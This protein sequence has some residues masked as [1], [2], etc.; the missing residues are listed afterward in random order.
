MKRRSL[1]R[2]RADVDV[3]VVQ[4][5]VKDAQGVFVS[6]TDMGSLADQAGLQHG[7]III[8]LNR[9]PIQSVEQYKDALGK[10]DLKRGALIFFNRQGT[11]SYALVK[12]A[13]ED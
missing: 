11:V 1:P 10:T 9:Q 2:R 6:G 13:R 5:D 12:K 8:E 3:P 4:L 7:D